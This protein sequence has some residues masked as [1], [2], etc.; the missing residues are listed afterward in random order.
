MTLTLLSLA[1]AAWDL[2]SLF[3]NS[4][5]LAEQLGAGLLGLLGVVSVVLA[6]VFAFN[7]LVSEQSR[8]GWPTIIMLF[9]LGG[10]LIGGSI[11]LFLG[12]AE[13]AKTTIDQLGTGLILFGIGG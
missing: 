10:L 1:P 5:S 11:S 3:E 2:L 7:K 4:A 12:I 9:L 13:G 8:R 6:L